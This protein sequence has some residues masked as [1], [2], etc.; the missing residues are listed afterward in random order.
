MPHESQLDQTQRLLVA[1]M[2]AKAKQSNKFEDVRKAFRAGKTDVVVEIPWY[3]DGGTHQL[4]LTRLQDDR[5][6]FINPLG[7]G[8]AL[9]GATLSDGGLARRV[10]G[11]STES[12]TIGE[13][14]SVFGAGQA[15]A[16]IP[17]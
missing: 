2:G 6:Y 5:V 11:D 13:L 14:E 15:R 3:S 16:L 12:A 10:E 1:V 7:H 17:R 4:I 8:E 9:A